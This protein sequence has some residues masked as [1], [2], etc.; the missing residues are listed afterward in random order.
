MR[1]EEGKHETWIK[2]QTNGLS[3]HPAQCLFVLQYLLFL[4]QLHVP[5]ISTRW[6][7]LDTPPVK[8]S[9]HWL[10]TCGVN[11]R[12]VIRLCGITRPTRGI[13]SF[14]LDDQFESSSV[15][16]DL[17]VKFRANFVT[18]GGEINGPSGVC[19]HEV[20]DEPLSMMK[21]STSRMKVLSSLARSVENSGSP[22]PLALAR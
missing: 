21:A 16:C 17:G 6:H 12:R 22:E 13:L 1:G 15:H 11:V 14:R 10:L 19:T 4:A 7:S 2:T 3:N 8:R 9:S 18:C 5:P 20:D